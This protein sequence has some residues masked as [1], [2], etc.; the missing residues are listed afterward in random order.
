MS[1][2]HRP[3]CLTVVDSNILRR[4]AIS[5]LFKEWANSHNLETLEAAPDDL[6]TPLDGSRIWRMVLLSV[7]HDSIQTGALQISLRH[8]QVISSTVP[9]VIV[10]DGETAG[11]IVASYRAGCN[12]YLPTK[13]Q[14]EVAFKTLDFIL[15]GGTYFPPSVLVNREVPSS[16]G[17]ECNSEDF[18]VEPARCVHED[19]LDEAETK[20]PSSNDG[21][22]AAPGESTTDSRVSGLTDRQ[23]QVLFRLHKGEPNKI[24]ARALGVTEGTV[25]VHVR[26][27]MRRLG[28]ANRTQAVVLCRTESQLAELPPITNGPVVDESS[29]KQVGLVRIR[30][31][32]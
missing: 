2:Q 6:L 28:A 32:S 14:P 13:L 23:H 21:E 12:G 15:A 7:G 16:P 11:E 19:L 8:L 18:D 1:I 30:R 20:P 29:W 27:I 3:L 5:G 31:S 10:S 9:I 26:Q 24:I 4:A 17:P 25:K 22:V